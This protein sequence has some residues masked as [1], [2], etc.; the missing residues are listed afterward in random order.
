MKS[1]PRIVKHI[2]PALALFLLTGPVSTAV[3][4][5]ELVEAAL[6]Q[7]PDLETQ[8]GNLEAGY[9]LESNLPWWD[10]PEIRLGYGRDSK[11]SEV[12]RSDSYPQ[13]EYEA[14]LR[15]FPRNPWERHAERRRLQSEN[16]ILELSLNEQ[17]GLVASQVK[18]LYWSLVYLDSEL[19]IKRQLLDVLVEQ[20]QRQAKLLE[21]G[22]I[23]VAQSLSSKMNRLELAMELDS[24]ER[25]AAELAANL[26]VLCAIEA[27]QIEFAEPLALTEASFDLPYA[28]WQSIAL[29]QSANVRI[30]HSQA[31]LANAEMKLLKAREI[32]WVKHI[33]ANYNV[34][35][36]FG[37]EDSA[38]VQI[39]INLP[40]FGNDGGEKRVASNRI[41]TYSRQAS[42]ARKM[43]EME[44]QALVQEFQNFEQ[45]WHS[46]GKQ[47]SQMQR[48][49]SDAIE[50]MDSGGS[51]ANESFWDSKVSL[52]QLQLKELQL[53]K[54]YLNLL[55]K[56]ETVVGL[57]L[58]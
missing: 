36:D 43:T 7:H 34:Q 39:A 29:N 23:T 20:E 32:P 22:Q 21:S 41:D 14:A 19:S 6:Q 58:L 55:M 33:Q 38:S 1:V 56:A 5:D 18:E 4:L 10:A 11:V 52:L 40:F 17:E 13:H 49:L 44:V 48:E 9:I 8:R 26:G 31:E 35:N 54:S 42:Q 25:S 50:K 15:V 45:S 28:S 37:D 12:F 57:K 30:P 53:S 2:V 47:L 24:N 51:H 16:D 46:H 27:G 3:T